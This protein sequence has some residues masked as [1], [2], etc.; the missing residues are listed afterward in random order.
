VTRLR[1]VGLTEVEVGEQ[2]A[3]VSGRSVPEAVTAA[4]SHRTQGNPF[5]VGELGRLFECRSDRPESW[6]VA[7]LPAGVRDA[8][9]GRLARLSQDCRIVVSAAAVLGPELNAD[10][11]AVLTERS[12]TQVLT[13][14]DEAVAA[15]I[16]ISPTAGGIGSRFR[17]DLVREA[18]LTEVGTVE[19]LGLH[20]RMVCYLRKRSDVNA[21]VAEVAFHAMASLPI[22]DHQQA[23]VWA[24]RAAQE[25]AMQLAWENAVHW[26]GRA[27]TTG[28]DL[29]IT[30]RCRLLLGLAQTQMRAYDAE[31]AQRSLLA[32]GDLARSVGDVY[33]VAE[34]ALAMEGGTDWTM[35]SQTLCEEALAGLSAADSALR[36]RLL[37]QLAMC[38]SSV[39]HTDGTIAAEPVSAAA[40]AMAERVGDRAALVAALRARQM[41]RS[42]PDGVAE[43]NTLGDRLLALGMEVRDDE[44]V[45]WGRLWRFDALSQLGEIDQAEAE[46]ESLAAVT[47]RLRSPLARSHLLRGRIAI[48]VARGRFRVA[49][50][51]LDELIKVIRRSGDEGALLPCFIHLRALAT[52]TG[53]EPP[54]HEITDDMSLVAPLRA[55][56]AVMHLALGRRAQAQRLYVQIPPL[57][58]TAAFALLDA[59]DAR[60]H[61]AAAF[62]DPAAATEVYR[63]LLPFADL[64]VAAGAGTAMIRGS[65]RLP[66]GVAAEALGR[67]DDATKHLRAA[68]EINERAGSPPFAALAQ[69][70]L[71]RVL[72][73]RRRPGDRDEA[74][75]LVALAAATAERLGMAPLLRDARELGSSIAGNSPG[76]LTRREQEI[77]VL[78][79]QGLTNRQIAAI[80]HIAE[81]TAE[82]HV[83][84]ILAKLGFTTRT[85]IAAW[86]VRGDQAPRAR[87]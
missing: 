30:D 32:A 46:V 12:V 25:A 59:L 53:E 7:D 66:L 52:L 19:R 34:A 58:D 1:L 16:V 51:L 6:P 37:A 18:A 62:S 33:A 83:Q 24:E 85:Q 72:V 87:R 29:P 76:P 39:H 10:C 11:L 42:G 35:T 31:G 55:T 61:S 3:A 15:G 43:R 77:A 64:F 65:V 63:M 67:L 36:A 71:A 9:H 84:H 79:G 68:T 8:V 57:A 23:V 56:A 48:A 78:V 73:R 45:L 54:L 20:H 81:R 70:H 44:S 28:A 49:Q 2:L 26:Y 41:A 80:A 17:H 27:L 60:A 74:A 50:T 69:Y 86:I 38:R 75:A 4:V 5:F 40:L 14:L 21:R 82:N 13:G 47:E 22:G